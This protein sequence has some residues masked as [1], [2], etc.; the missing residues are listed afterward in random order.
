MGLEPSA[1]YDN[2]SLVSVGADGVIFSFAGAFTGAKA[3][4][5]DGNSDVETWPVT[6]TGTAVTLNYSG[7]IAPS[8]TPSRNLPAPMYCAFGGLDASLILRQPREDP[9]TYV[10]GTT[11]SIWGWLSDSKYFMRFTYSAAV[12]TVAQSI[13]LPYWLN[14]EGTN[15]STN[16]PGSLKAANMDVGK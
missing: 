5:C 3:Y 7:C 4:K 16:T 14:L 2:Y 11:A 12:L 8:A 13:A 15:Y 10:S 9:E 6:I 1:L